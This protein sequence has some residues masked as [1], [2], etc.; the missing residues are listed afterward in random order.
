[1]LKLRDGATT[2]APALLD[3]RDGARRAS[4]SVDGNGAA[5]RA[6]LHWTSGIRVRRVYHAG[7]SLG[8]AG[9]RERDYSATEERLG[10]PQILCIELAE[11]EA[12]VDV[13]AALRDADAV[14]WAQVEPLASV[15]PLTRGLSV[16][17]PA[18]HAAFDCVGAHQA[19]R[20][21]P[22]LPAIRVAVID[23]GVSLEHL[24]FSGK[25][26]GGYDTVDLGMGIVADGIS[27]VGD[28]LGRDFCA[29]DETGHGSHVAGI[30]GALGRSMEHGVAGACR[31][32]P[33]RALAAARA[34]GGPVFGVGGL[35]DIDAGIKAAVD[36]G[37]KVLN[38]SFGTAADD[39]DGEAPPPHADSIA[40]AIAR[41]AIPVAAMGNSGRDEDFYP[42]A[43]PDVIA[44]GSM[45]L[46]GEVSSFST[47]G[48]HV[49]LCA[50]GEDV[51]SARIEGYGLSTGTSHAAPFV[52]GACALMA[53]RARRLGHDLTA[54]QARRALCLS[55]QGYGRDPDAD[56]G[57][58]MLQIPAALSAM[59]DLIA[60]PEELAT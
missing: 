19:L 5:D 26:A 23:T 27:L 52:A 34:D 47:R 36:L 9:S 11:K 40:Y 45:S 54:G 12:T 57:W 53:A 48:A 4:G 55:A 6:I 8:K 7:G 1:M 41:G 17:P 3:V 15:P 56:A 49:A 30:I 60:V 31:I 59:D 13:L 10:L 24:E 46:T 42:A 29:R 25:L 16:T 28:S 22:G 2:R 58:G 21:E 20:I 44:V 33:I 18:R 38:M 39:L 35:S 32:V 14:E 51:L 50:P 43:L 37:A